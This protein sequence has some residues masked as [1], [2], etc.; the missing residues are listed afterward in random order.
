M[1]RRS[2]WKIVTAIL[3]VLVLLLFGTFCVIYL[4][5]YVEMTNENRQLLAQYV[6]NYALPEEEDRKSVV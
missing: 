3:S 2:R 5:S 4:A 1:F 6:D